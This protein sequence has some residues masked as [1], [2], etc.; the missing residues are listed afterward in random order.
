M[1]RALCVAVLGLGEAG[2]EIGRDLVAAGAVVRGYDPVVAAAADVVACTSEADAVEGAALV[3]SVNSAS[4]AVRAARSG[5]PAL[6]AGSLWA[7]LNTAAPSTKLA[8]A[9]EL[10]GTPA[11]FVDVALMAPVPGR[12]LRTPML[13]SGPGAAR[14]AE[15]LRA[16]GAHVEVL[17]DVPG[18]AATRKLVRS[19][20]YK[21]L[22]AAVV[23]ALAAARAAGCEAPLRADIAAELAQ[24]TAATVD[25]LEQGSRR[26]ALRRSHEM[27]AAAQLLE[28]LGVAPRIAAAS[29]DQLA[30]LARRGTGDAPPAEGPVA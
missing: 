30:E 17:G 15:V 9:R 29:R 8:V 16:L 5:A 21:G 11:S 3:L 1:S 6:A 4:D 13:A 25:V 20:F 14:C 19:V 7:D 10:A 22:A 26:H 28:E 27:A 2:S 23:E 24:A 18:D 12:G